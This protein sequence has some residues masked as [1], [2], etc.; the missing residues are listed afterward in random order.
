[1]R[2]FLRELR[3]SLLSMWGGTLLSCGLSLAVS[4]LGATSIPTFLWMLLLGSFLVAL[5]GILLFLASL[6]LEACIRILDQAPKGVTED[7][8]IQIWKNTFDRHGQRIVIPFILGC[9]LALGGILSLA[10]RFF[11]YFQSQAVGSN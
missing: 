7:D 6:R 8:L 10:L 4:T 5:S 2:D 3:P 11:L 1:M 9:I